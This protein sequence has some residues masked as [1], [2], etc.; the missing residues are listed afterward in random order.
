MVVHMIPAGS[1][2]R[3]LEVTGFEIAEAPARPPG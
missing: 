1:V 2:S 3:T